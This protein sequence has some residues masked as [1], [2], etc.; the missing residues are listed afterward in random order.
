MDPPEWYDKCA[1][2]IGD[3]EEWA[4]RQRFWEEREAVRREREWHRREA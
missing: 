1:R 4:M 3:R 2:E